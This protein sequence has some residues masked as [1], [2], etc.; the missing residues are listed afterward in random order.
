MA[1]LVVGRTKSPGTTLSGKKVYAGVAAWNQHQETI[2]KLY[3]E[4]NKPLREVRKIMENE[5]SFIAT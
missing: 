2:S 3:V 4:E 1:P 5:H